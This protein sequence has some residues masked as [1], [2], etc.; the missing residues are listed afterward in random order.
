MRKLALTTLTAVTLLAG[1][2]L[3]HAQPPVINGPGDVA[4]LD[5]AS[6]TVDDSV[7]AAGEVLEWTGLVRHCGAPGDSCDHPSQPPACVRINHPD[8]GVGFG[9]ACQDH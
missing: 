2:G 6:R 9:D 1:M 7:Y 4:A 5:K 3:A 8:T